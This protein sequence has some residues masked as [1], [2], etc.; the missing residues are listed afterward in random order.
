[1]VSLLHLNPI[2]SVPPR[3]PILPPNKFLFLAV[4]EGPLSLVVF[5]LAAT[6][7]STWRSDTCYVQGRICAKLKLAWNCICN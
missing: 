6:M 2:P 3:L 5:A 7:L 4:S 1:M